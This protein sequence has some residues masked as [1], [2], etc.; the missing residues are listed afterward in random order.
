MRLQKNTLLKIIFLLVL[1]PVS[2][3]IVSA[4]SWDWEYDMWVEDLSEKYSIS[5]DLVKSVIKAES[6]F[7]YAISPKGAVGFMQLMPETAKLLGVKDINDPVENIKGGIKYLSLLMKRFKNNAPL[8]VAAY[9]AG[10]SAVARYGGIPPYK[11]TKKYV[12]KV[13][14]Y[15]RQYSNLNKSEK[16]S[17]LSFKIISD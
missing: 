8:A 9:N 16:A 5:P 12:F 11:E 4:T 13:M 3:N 6:N 10:P 14:N 15:Y 7:R 17:R 1:I 2:A